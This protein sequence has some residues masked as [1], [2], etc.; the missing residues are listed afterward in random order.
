ML[1][2]ITDDGEKD[3]SD[4]CLADFSGFCQPI[5]GVYQEF[6]SDGDKL[7]STSTIVSRAG[8]QHAYHSDDYQEP[9]AHINIHPGFL[10]F[11]I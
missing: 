3:D 4:E 2:S 5:D 9:K 6:R 10:K 7:Y 8:N 11:F 1:S